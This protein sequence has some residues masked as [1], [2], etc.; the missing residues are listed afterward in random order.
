VD[1]PCSGLGT[2]R[3]DPD[4]KWRRTPDDLPAFAAEQVRLLRRVAPLIAVGGRL[5]YSTCSSEPEENE[6]VV[7]A[8]LREAS[9]FVR[10]PLPHLAAVAADIADMATSDG[11]LRT[12]P[13]DGLEAFFGAVLERRL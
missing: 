8:F 9:N 2:V 4:I 11:Y 12:T 10:M 5:I 3:R 6:E 13:H 1:A 7:A